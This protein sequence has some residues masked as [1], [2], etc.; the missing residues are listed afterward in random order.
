MQGVL[1]VRRKNTK[2][3]LEFS[4]CVAKVRTSQREAIMQ[5]FR[6]SWRTL[7]QANIDNC[8]EDYNRFEATVFGSVIGSREILWDTECCGSSNCLSVQFISFVIPLVFLNNTNQP[9]TV[10]RIG[11]VTN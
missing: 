5:Q 9:I 8:L 3:L 10:K 11:Q 4:D 7:P 2:L 1:V 6:N